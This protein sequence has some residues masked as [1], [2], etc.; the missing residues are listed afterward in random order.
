VRLRAVHCDDS[1][2][3]R[4]LVRE[5]LTGEPGIEIVGEAGD[6][7]E[8]LREVGAQQPDVVLLDLRFDGSGPAFLQRLREAAP[9]VRIVVLSGDPDPGAAPGA[10]ARLDKGAPSQEIARAIR[11]VAAGR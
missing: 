1:A 9:G 8:A 6:V 3:Y 5:L 7:A 4:R 2:A 10:D 11:T